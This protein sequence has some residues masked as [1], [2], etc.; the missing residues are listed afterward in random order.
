MR[1]L[2]ALL[3]AIAWPWGAAATDKTDALGRLY[4]LD[5]AISACKGIDVA[6]ADQQKL[7]DAIDAAERAS[8]LD[9]A[10][11][12][13]VYDDLE[14]AAEKDPA[15]FCASEAPGLATALKSLP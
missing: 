12:Q 15:A 9:E 13:K 14:S 3:L 10:A 6:D 4:R 8:G 5:L 2:V 11:R 7:D 1:H